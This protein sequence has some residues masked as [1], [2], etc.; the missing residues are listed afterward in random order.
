[1][2]EPARYIVEAIEPESKWFFRDLGIREGDSIEVPDG[3]PSGPDLPDPG[4]PVT[5]LH[6]L[7]PNVS[8]VLGAAADEGTV[9]LRPVGSLGEV[10][11]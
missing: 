3:F 6:E 5:L 2:S 11:S 1:M 8:W 4:E 9:K 10:T 7:H